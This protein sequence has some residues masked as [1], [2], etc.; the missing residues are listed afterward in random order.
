MHH[1][2]KRQS[3]DLLLCV[4]KDFA[5]NFC[6]TV[7]SLHLIDRGR[8]LFPLYLRIHCNFLVIVNQHSTL[9]TFL[10]ST[11]TY[12]SYPHHSTIRSPIPIPNPFLILSSL[13]VHSQTLSHVIA[14]L[15]SMIYSLR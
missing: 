11:I 12:S 3:P 14:L 9:D 1:D 5:K 6:F 10:S 15:R 2:D 13:H 8:A 7:P 4:A